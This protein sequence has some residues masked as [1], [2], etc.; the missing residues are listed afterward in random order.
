MECREIQ[1]LIGIYWDL[2]KDDIRRGSVDEH[3]KRCAS[4]AEEFEI[5]QESTDLIQFSGS[6]LEMPGFYSKVSKGVMDRIYSDES[7]RIPVPDRIYTISYKSRR[8]ISA[9]IA[10][11]L[12]LFLISFLYSI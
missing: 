11:C 9:I 1:D 5:W 3:M 2:P 6:Q 12:A 10:F 7:W 8:N 4:C